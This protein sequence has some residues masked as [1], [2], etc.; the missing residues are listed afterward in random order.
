M[1]YKKM[2]GKLQ[3]WQVQHHAVITIRTLIT[4]RLWTSLHSSSLHSSTPLH[5]S[6]QEGVAQQPRRPRRRV[7]HRVRVR[8]RVRVRCPRRRLELVLLVS[9]F[10]PHCSGAARTAGRCTLDRALDFAAQ[11]EGGQ[12]LWGSRLLKYLHRSRPARGALSLFTVRSALSM[13][14]ATIAMVHPAC[15]TAHL[16]GEGA[17]VSTCMQLGSLVGVRD[18]APWRPA[19]SA[20]AAWTAAST[21]RRQC[22]AQTPRERPRRRAVQTPRERPRRRAAQTPRERPRRRAAQTP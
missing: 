21:P 2:T 11:T 13:S 1:L 22:A 20:A 10:P 4:S 7:E 16:W 12:K 15:V 9:P 5:L 17:A 14:V 8:V 18:G 3:V 19:S 6:N